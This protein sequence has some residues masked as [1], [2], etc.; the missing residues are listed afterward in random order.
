LK[1]RRQALKGAFSSAAVIGAISTGAVSLPSSRACANEAGPLAV[2]PIR[3]WVVVP[4]RDGAIDW[5]SLVR[6]AVQADPVRIS[7]AVLALNR[8]WVE[9]DG[10]FLPYLPDRSNVFLL[11]PYQAHCEGCLP[12]RPFS[13][14]GISAKRDVEDDGKVHRI[15]GQFVVAP[16]NPSGYPFWILEAEPLHT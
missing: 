9:I 3:D 12:N 5:A 1:N 4:K 16:D 11:T 2:P 7:D 15:R 14:V 13:V 6:H 8:T 10:Y